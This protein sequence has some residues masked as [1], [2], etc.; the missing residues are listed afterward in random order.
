MKVDVPILVLNWSWW[1]VASGVLQHC[2][3][4]DHRS[5]KMDLSQPQEE[6]FSVHYLFLHIFLVL[7]KTQQCQNGDKYEMGLKTKHQVILWPIS[8]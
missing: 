5:R 8:T 6:A 1:I 4:S 7:A 2:G 3:I